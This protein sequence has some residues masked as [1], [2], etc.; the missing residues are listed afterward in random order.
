MCS[1]KQD[2]AFLWIILGAC[3]FCGV[4][5]RGSAH[6]CSFSQ[7]GLTKSPQ[8]TEKKGSLQHPLCRIWLELE[9]EDAGQGGGDT[10]PPCTDPSHT[11][12]YPNPVWAELRHTKRT[13]RSLRGFPNQPKLCCEEQTLP[14]ARPRGWGQEDDPDPRAGRAGS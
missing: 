14:S 2:P 12:P 4:W 7:Q 5:D 1:G 6:G 9:Q 11:N 13:L 8:I 10:D 3:G